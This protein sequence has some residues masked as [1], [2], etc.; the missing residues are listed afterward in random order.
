MELRGWCWK[1]PYLLLMDQELAK[2]ERS[3]SVTKSTRE[4]ATTSHRDELNDESRRKEILSSYILYNSIYQAHM[5]KEKGNLMEHIDRRLGLDFHKKEVTT[6]INV[7]L[8][9]TNDTTILKPTM[10]S[11]VSKFQGRFVLEVVSKPSEALDEKKLEAT[12]QHDQE[13]E[14]NKLRETQNWSLS[15]DDT[16]VASSI[17]TTYLYPVNMNSSYWEKKGW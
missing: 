1:A 16:L 3:L 17:S 6:M 2:M 5:L 4:R 15:M 10:S 7:A 12:Q 8:L 11:V 13:I 14:E 9:C